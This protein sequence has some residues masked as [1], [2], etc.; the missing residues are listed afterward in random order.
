MD[1]NI[2]DFVEQSVAK[3]KDQG[4]KW[5]N[6]CD[7]NIINHFKTLDDFLNEIVEVF[8]GNKRSDIK[9][10]DII[11][12]IV[13]NYWGINVVKFVIKGETELYIP[14]YIYNISQY[15]TE[16]NIIII[17]DDDFVYPV[18]ILNT[19]NFFKKVQLR[20]KIVWPKDLPIIKTIKQMVS[21]DI[22]KRVRYNKNVNIYD[23]IEFC[24]ES[25]YDILK[26]YVNKSGYCYALDLKLNSV[27]H[28]PVVESSIPKKYKLS[29]D[30]PTEIGNYED[31]ELYIYDINKFL[32]EN[33]K[34][35]I[36]IKHLYSFNG[37][38]IG[39]N[40]NNLIYRTKGDPQ[41]DLPVVNMLYDPL[42]VNRSNIG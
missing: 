34:V 18:Y 14:S 7:G 2:I 11:I 20:S 33:D 12:D 1:I 15:L 16:H 10:N 24:E 23:I 8:L 40:G 9:W 29:Y 39:F 13:I 5:Y 22:N 32:T 26:L 30:L 35:K 27:F 17:E 3:I 37:D 21:Y 6:L 28:V 42:V 4:K 19:N 38:I 25:D 36:T 41:S 31:V